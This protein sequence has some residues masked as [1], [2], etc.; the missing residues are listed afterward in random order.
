MIS[1]NLFNIIKHPII[2]DKTT[3]ALE[4]NQ[5]CFAVSPHVDKEEIKVAVE[6][7]FNVKVKKVNSLHYPIKKRL[8][9]RFKGKKTHYKKVMVTLHSDNKIILFPE[10]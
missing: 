3:K 4:D 5:Y 8:V 6:C 1:Q 10:D 9:S 7:I 2:T